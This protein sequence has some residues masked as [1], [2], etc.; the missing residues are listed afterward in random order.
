MTFKYLNISPSGIPL[1]LTKG[2]IHIDNSDM[3]IE[4]E[5]ELMYKTI[6]GEI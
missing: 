3:T 5:V 6:K 4:E 1:I 2:T